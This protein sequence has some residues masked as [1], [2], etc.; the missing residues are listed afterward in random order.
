MGVRASQRLL[1]D[2]R[3]VRTH[4]V[5][6]SESC[7]VLNRDRV[8]ADGRTHS[9]KDYDTSIGRIDDGVAFD[10]GSRAGVR[11][12]VGPGRVRRV[13][14]AGTDVVEPD[15]RVLAVERA[16]GN[17]RATPAS[18]VETP[19]VLED[20]ARDLASHFDGRAIIYGVHAI[21]LTVNLDV[22]N[23][24]VRAGSASSVDSG[25]G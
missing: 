22:A 8:V 2:E 1:R 20:L 11:D 5:D 17:M 3:D 13:V 23:L 6:A 12:T 16:L 18:R 25:P 19:S 10:E 15:R 7:R 14:A 4:E 21:A 9:A 24:D